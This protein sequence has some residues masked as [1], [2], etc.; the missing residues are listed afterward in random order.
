MNNPG[1]PLRPHLGP[2]NNSNSSHTRL[3]VYL[4][5]VV[6]KLMSEVTQEEI[7]QACC[8]TNIL[9][10][11]NSLPKLVVFLSFFRMIGWHHCSICSG[12]D[13]EVGGKGSQL[14]GGQKHTCPNCD[15][16]IRLTLLCF[17]T[18]C[19]CPC[20]A[21]QSE[22]TFVHKSSMFASLSIYSLPP[23]YFCA[24]LTLRENHARCKHI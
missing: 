1:V 2:T 19:Y 5:F 3:L 6:P 15:C 9:D 14:S 8:N 20:P 17:R 18:H 23:G 12:F 4:S 24:Q 7:E 21:P 16:K 22:S 11:V 13:T 10:F